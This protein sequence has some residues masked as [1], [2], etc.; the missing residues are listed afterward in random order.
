MK[1]LLIKFIMARNVKNYRA[2][3]YNFR[4][5]N[6]IWCTTC[7]EFVKRPHKKLH[8]EIIR[9]EAEIEHSERQIRIFK[10]YLLELEKEYGTEFRSQ[11][12]DQ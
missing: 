12:Y 1:K 11:Y 4:N 6:H 8:M 7:N 5:D 2:K 10:Q 9:T 3:K